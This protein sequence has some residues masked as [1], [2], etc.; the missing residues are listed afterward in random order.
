MDPG[1]LWPQ[2]ELLLTPRPPETALDELGEALF[3]AGL[4]QPRREKDMV[5]A[6]GAAQGDEHCATGGTVVAPRSVAQPFEARRGPD[7][8]QAFGDEITSAHRPTTSRG[9]W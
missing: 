4:Y 5:C 8:H 3:A 1:E 6:F 2:G 7:G 9:G